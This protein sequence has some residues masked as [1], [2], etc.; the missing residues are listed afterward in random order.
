MFLLSVLILGIY[1]LIKFDIWRIDAGLSFLDLCLLNSF[2][3]CLIKMRLYV[4]LCCDC[5]VELCMLLKALKPES[6]MPEES[7]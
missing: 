4:H 7:S 5:F 2:G 6:F 3:L 1:I